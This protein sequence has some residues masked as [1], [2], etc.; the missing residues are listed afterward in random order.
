MR[1]LIVVGSGIAGLFTTL[2]ARRLGVRDVV[3]VTKAALEESATRY[4]QG[5]IAAAIGDGDSWELHEA[6][7]LGAGADL[8]D[9]E[10]VRVLAGEAADRVADL[11][12]LGVRFDTENGGFAHAREGAHSM[13]RV[14][15][16]EGDATGR[17]IERALARAVRQ[18]GVEVRDRTFLS[19]L[20]IE[21]GA[22]RG[23][24]LAGGD[25]LETE[26]V[27]LAAGGA[28]QLYSRTTNPSISTGDGVAL[29]LRAGAVVA[30]LE[31]FQFHPT[32]FA[33]SGAAHFLISEAVRGHGAV[34]RNH[35]GAPFMAGYDP[36]AELAPR[37]IV[38]RSIVHEMERHRL[39]HVWLDATHLPPG[40][41][42]R[43]F[44]TIHAYCVAHRCDPEREPI[45][46]SPAAHYMMGGVWTDA[47][48][49]TSIPGLFAC[50]ETAS[51]GVHGANRLASNSLLEGVVFGARVAHALT[52]AATLGP[53]PPV[54]GHAEEL[55]L[56]KPVS[57]D[58]VRAALP[59]RG[60]LQALL[61]E[62]LGILRHRAGL[63][64]AR[65]TLETAAA[66]LPRNGTESR[67]TANLA[68][69]GCVMAEAALRRQESRG[70]HYRLDFP[71]PRPEWRRRQL[72][73][74]RPGR[75]DHLP[76]VAE[77]GPAACG[78][79]S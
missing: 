27:V 51:T 59:T 65:A 72:F 79:R 44:P 24:R 38:A 42:R 71:E 25:T 40:E 76:R 50:G 5:G 17:H 9:P 4:A 45:P 2:T 64:Q 6:D 21:A 62:R 60:S 39:A 61:W 34:L 37:D 70:A 23:V 32:A 68:L 43:R 20:I 31:F 15:H 52:G 67:E 36:R 63:A 47:W 54:E 18:A 28:G 29:A 26:A 33:G 13:A 30:D 14:L 8:C 53:P 78:A 57:G 49:R 77:P 73:V 41:F 10:A 74:V 46:V 16:A 1:G 58:P 69:V 66:A 19:E 35:R 22:C 7:T 3:M 55:I 12:Q 48:G 56:A 75:V 11:I